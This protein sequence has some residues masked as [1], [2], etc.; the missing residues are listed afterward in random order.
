MRFLADSCQGGRYGST[1]STV[2]ALRAIVAYDQVRS[3]RRAPGSVRVY[4]DGRPVGDAV[5]F[6][7]KSQEALKLPDV[8]ELLTPGKHHLELRMEE[9]SELPYSI[10]VTYHALVPASS[11][12]TRVTL[13]VALAKHAL[14]EGEPTEARVVVTNKTD[15]TLPT[16]VAIF[17]VP[18]GLEVRHDQL[19][20][21]V[22]KHA[23]DA[24]EVIGRDVVLYWR[25]MEPRKKL[26]VPLSLVA[27]VPGK[28]TGPASRAYLYY[29]DDHKIW[30]DGLEVSIA[31]R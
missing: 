18:G 16:T 26:D 21:L 8:A 20:E 2:L 3:A 22:K 9:G 11:P 23:V 15:E 24:Y 31:P 7:A 13:E 12:D 6:D 5:K 14:T 4:V 28:Y 30:R 25:G 29:S 17:G 19:K 10:E 27:A 1:Q